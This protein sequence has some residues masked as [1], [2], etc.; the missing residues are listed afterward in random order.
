MGRGVGMDIAKK[1]VELLRGQIDVH[2]E[3]GSGCTFEIRLPATLAIADAI[4]VKVGI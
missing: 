3:K 2:T 4:L 1:G